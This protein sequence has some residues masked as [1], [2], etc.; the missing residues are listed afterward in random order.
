MAAG[1]RLIGISSLGASRAIPHYAFIGASKAALEA[2]GRSQRRRIGLEVE[3]TCASGEL[4][5]D[6]DQ[7]GIVGY[8]WDRNAGSAS[9]PRLV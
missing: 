7:V 5:E 8:G 4:L 1:G 9:S 2:L 3:R 6:A